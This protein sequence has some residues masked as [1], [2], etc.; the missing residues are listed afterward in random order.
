TYEYPST[1]DYPKS[2]KSTVSA[3]KD[4]IRLHDKIRTYMIPPAQVGNQVNRLLQSFGKEVL[5]RAPDP[6]DL[7]N[8]TTKI[9]RDRI[10][11]QKKTIT[12]TR[13]TL[14][15]YIN[16]IMNYKH[17]K[18][19]IMRTRKAIIDD[20]E[21]LKRTYAAVTKDPESLMRSHIR[22]LKDPDREAFL[23]HEYTRYADIHMEMMRLFNGYIAIYKA[24]FDTKL[25][26]L[27]EKIES[28]KAAITEVFT[29]T[30]VFA[31]INTKT[32]SPI[33]R[34]E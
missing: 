32:A 5:E 4:I 33:P 27:T 28:N 24:A 20:Y 22:D 7:K 14:G 2:L 3:E 34:T 21:S 10:R 9:V 12:I 19:D 11:G 8:S 6:D 29:R 13:E 18:D 17:D 15:I 25:Q 23:A 1:K 16:E 26:C 31:A 30:G